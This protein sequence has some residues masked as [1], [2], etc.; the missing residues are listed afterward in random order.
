MRLAVLLAAA[1]GAASFQGCEESTGNPLAGPVPEA[2]GLEPAAAKKLRPALCA[3]DRGDFTIVSHN[4]YFPIGV[5]SSWHFFGEEEGV[6]LELLITVLDETENVGGVTTRVIEER[7]WEDGDL[8][9][10]SRNYY[11]ET[12]EE[13]VCYFG[14]AVDI[15]EDGEIVS[16][17]GAWRADDPGNAPGIFMPGDPRPGMTYKMENAPG[18]A[19]DTG[20]IVG[21]RAVRVPAGRF[22]T[23]R[24]QETNPLDGGV[25]YKYFAEGVG[26]VIDGP[27]LLE[28]YE[29]VGLVDDD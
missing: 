7:E 22:W 20:K 12:S 27:A 19:E 6:E 17:D 2:A 4:E 9:E 24:V 18:I 10:V 26:L 16:H 1:L 8:L 13:T 25:G 23:I 3:L 29:V 11:A 14:E 28:E 5:G 21:F 15:Y